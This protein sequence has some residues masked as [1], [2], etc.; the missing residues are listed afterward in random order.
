VVLSSS[1]KCVSICL[2]ENLTNRV[3]IG[4]PGQIRSPSTASTS[5]YPVSVAFRPDS[6]TTYTANF[7]DDTVSVIDVATGAPVGNAIWLDPET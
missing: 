3:H 7:D 5:R 2:P 4:T 1:E 6:T